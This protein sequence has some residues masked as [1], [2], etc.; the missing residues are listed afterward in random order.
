ME[1]IWLNRPTFPHESVTEYIRVTVNGHFS[2]WDSSETRLNV[3]SS[4]PQ[5]S[6]AEPPPV[7]NDFKS[8]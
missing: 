8:G 4:N 6:V 5:L 7:I 1:I 2:S 3:S